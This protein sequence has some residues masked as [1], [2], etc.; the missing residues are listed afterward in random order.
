[1]NKR[2]PYERRNPIQPGGTNK[3]QARICCDP[4]NRWI[5]LLTRSKDS[6]TV[7][8]HKWL[9]KVLPTWVDYRLINAMQ[10]LVT[11]RFAIERSIETSIWTL[12]ADILLAAV[13]ESMVLNS[14][15]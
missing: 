5:D 10:M 14:G 6:L 3:K 9:H 1:M 4:M 12:P 7:S 8:L 11:A 15:V 13:P 2:T